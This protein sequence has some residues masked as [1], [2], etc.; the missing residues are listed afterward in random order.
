L[1]IVCS[2]ILELVGAAFVFGVVLQLVQIVVFDTLGIDR[3]LGG[4]MWISLIVV[5]VTTSMAVSYFCHRDKANTHD[6]LMQAS[7]IIG[8]LV[9]LWSANIW[10]FGIKHA[11]NVSTKNAL[12]TV[13]VPVGMYIVYLISTII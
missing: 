8:I 4:F 12:I 1:E 5:P 10:I 11:R 2:R 6:P 7:G 3:M 9:V 13:G